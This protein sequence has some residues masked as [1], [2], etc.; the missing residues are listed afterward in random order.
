MTESLSVGSP[1]WASLRPGP[2]LR[3][4]WGPVTGSFEH[5][6]EPLGSLKGREFLDCLLSHVFSWLVGYLVRK[7]ASRPSRV[8]KI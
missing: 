6:N 4:G 5:D 8:T 2:G 1:G 3:L 7:K